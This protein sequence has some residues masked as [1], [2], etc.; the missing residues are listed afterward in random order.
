MKAS[1]F[2]RN[3][4]VCDWKQQK[5]FD[6]WLRRFIH[7]PHEVLGGWVKPGMTVIDAG[8]G[9]GYFSLGMAEL[10]G[11]RGKVISVDLQEGAL[12]KL[13]SKAEKIGFTS[14]IETYKCEA[15]SLGTLPKADFALA[16]WMVHETPDAGNFFKQLYASLGKN[17]Y[18]LFTEPPLHVSGKRF[19]EEIDRA[20]QAGF[21]FLGQP[22]IR[23]CQSALFE[24]Q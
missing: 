13:E 3:D 8:C 15:D 9:I 5:G 23:F 18:M 20:R 21:H 2:R 4:H 24:K 16:F 22:K 6:G 17:S 1:F 11:R 12:A 10:V 19:R 7:P 14:V